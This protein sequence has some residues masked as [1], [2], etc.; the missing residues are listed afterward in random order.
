[1]AMAYHGINTEH[2]ED[3]IE[4]FEDIIGMRKPF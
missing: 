4:F 3:F 1:M 2:D